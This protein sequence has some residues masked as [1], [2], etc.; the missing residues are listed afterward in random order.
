MCKVIK[1]GEDTTAIICGG[2]K[3]HECNEDAI[4]YETKDGDRYFFTDKDEE[5][6]W[7]NE[8]YAE[9]IM[10]SV[11]CSICGSAAFDNFKVQ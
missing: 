1:I 7:Y 5:R 11:A 4:V 6:R 9:T 8:H 3:D 2:K 10:G